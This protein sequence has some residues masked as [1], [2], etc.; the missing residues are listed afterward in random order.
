MS[1]LASNICRVSFIEAE[2]LKKTY[3]PRGASPVHALDGLDLAVPQGT[4]TALLGPNG[5]G[6]TTA[7]KVLTTLVTPDSGT[8]MIDGIDVIAHP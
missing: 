3:T 1:R 5:A 7:V 8:A 2:S 6:K 4:V